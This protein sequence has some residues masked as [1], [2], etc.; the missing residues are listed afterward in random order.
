MG[1]AA[2]TWQA[3]LGDQL[4]E[5]VGKYGEKDFILGQRDDRRWSQRTE[6]SSMLPGQKRNCFAILSTVFTE[7]LS[8]MA[9]LGH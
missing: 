2:T 4:L 3:A 1:S 6:I 5:T 9:I 7:V 8:L